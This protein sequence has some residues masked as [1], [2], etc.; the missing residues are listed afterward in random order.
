MTKQ[1]ESLH[2]LADVCLRHDDLESGCAEC[3]ICR[4][5]VRHRQAGAPTEHRAAL[6]RA[7]QVGTK[8]NKGRFRFRVWGAD[9][10]N[11]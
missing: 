11:P 10:P 9:C 8:P 4:T 5:A 1:N 3:V 2:L 6:M 7:L